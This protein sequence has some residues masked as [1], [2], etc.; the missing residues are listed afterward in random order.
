MSVNGKESCGTCHRQEFAFTDGRGARARHHGTASSAQQHEP[1]ERGVRAV[2][3]V[4]ESHASLR[5]KQQA[6]IPMLG[7]EP[8][9]LGLKGHE[10]EFLNTVRRDP[11]YQATLPEGIPGERRSLHALECDQGHRGV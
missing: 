11:I 10:Q 5:L 4:G 3:D 6:L 7:E 9:E 2:V 1:G 8:I